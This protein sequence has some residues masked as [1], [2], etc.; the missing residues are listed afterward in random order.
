MLNNF[1]LGSGVFLIVMGT[2]LLFQLGTLAGLLITS[3][4]MLA[5]AAVIAI[6]VDHHG[7]K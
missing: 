5:S 6:A 3:G 7:R 2:A 4:V 1:T